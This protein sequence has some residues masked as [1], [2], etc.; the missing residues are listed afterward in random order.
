MRWLDGITDSMDLSLSKLRELMMGRDACHGAAHGVAK[1]WTQLSNSTEL[2]AR[3]TLEVCV[4]TGGFLLTQIDELVSL[5][6]CATDQLDDVRP[7][8]QI[9]EAL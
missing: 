3:P 8:V 4:S 7:T 5:P 6:M 2:I 9:T 1:S